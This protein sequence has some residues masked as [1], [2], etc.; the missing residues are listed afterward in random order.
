M[1]GKYISKQQCFSDLFFACRDDNTTVAGSDNETESSSGN[2]IEQT[3]NNT[4][5]NILAGVD[6]NES[7][8]II[9]AINHDY[10]DLFQR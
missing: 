6:V 4:W 8:S 9:T 3:L 10:D 1:S 2:E 5:S 7:A